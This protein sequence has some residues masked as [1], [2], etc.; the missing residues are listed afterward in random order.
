MIPPELRAR[1]RRFFFVEHWRIGT[2]ATELGVHPDTVRRA[3]ESERF[4]GTV[5]K[6]RCTLLDPYRAFIAD[7][8]ERHPRLRSTRLFEM[9]RDR[10]YQGSAVQLRRYVRTVRPR[11]REAYLRLQTLPGEQGQVDWA[12]FGKIRVGNASRNLSCFVL[13]LSWSRAMYARFALDQTLES[14]LRGHLEAF[15]TM[16]GVPRSLLYDN[17]KCVVLERVGD[18]IHFHPRLLDLAGHYHFAPKPCAVFRGNEKGR[19]ER[20]IQYLRTSFF[21]ARPFHSVTDLNVQLAAWIASTAHARKVPGDPTGRL[22]ADALDEE[23]ARLLP[24]PE[25]DLECDHLR[26]IASGKTPYL[27]FDGNDYSIPHDRLRKVLT[28]IA[29]EHLVRILDGTEEIARHTRSYDRGEVIEDPAHLAALAREKRHAHELRGRDLLRTTC[30]RADAFID[31]LALRGEP[32]AGHT[33]R[34]LKLLDRYGSAELDASI[35]EAISRGAI[36]AVSV[37]HILDRRARSRHEAPPLDV[38]LPDDPRV[39]DLRVT[40]HSLSNYDNLCSYHETEENP[41]EHTD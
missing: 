27:R 12:N 37:A 20:A 11:P 8:L 26:P 38:V 30:P 31:A 13:V 17:L 28:L 32:L 6:L 18:H 5:P 40:P 10:G 35:D 34:L 16:G 3:I 21:A 29:S 4:N 25:H 9:I 15:R 41:H 14:F 24:L 36:S 19:V 33:S 39:R 7:V 22:V 23:R 2:I 1:I